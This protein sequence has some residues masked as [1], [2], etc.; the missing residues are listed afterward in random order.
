VIA[1]ATT[2]TQRA[3]VPKPPAP[4]STFQKAGYAAC[5]KDN[6]VSGCQANVDKI[7]AQIKANP[8]QTVQKR[9]NALFTAQTMSGRYTPSTFADLSNAMTTGNKTYTSPTGQ[10]G[11][12]AKAA[13]SVPA[14]VAQLGAGGTLAA[15]ASASAVNA[16]I[17]RGLIT[18]VEWDVVVMLVPFAPLLLLGGILTS[19]APRPDNQETSSTSESP[20]PAQSAAPAGPPNPNDP[21]KGKNDVPQDPYTVAKNG[22]RNAGWYKDMM[23][24]PDSELLKGIRNI[25]KQ[26]TEH[27]GYIANP[28]SKIPDWKNLDPREQTGLIRSK[29][30]KDIARQQEQKAILE[31]ILKA[32]VK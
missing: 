27:E 16:Q 30:P 6:N 23:N 20:A 7:D 9:V 1:L 8:N 3:V 4:K 25:N 10:T 31:G 13:A 19:D 21:N 14:N 2:T 15:G 28:R 18:L 12:L 11:S 5:S 17:G 32:R 24:K 26:I 22:G 29:W